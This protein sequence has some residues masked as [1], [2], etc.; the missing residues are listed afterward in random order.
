MEIKR[1]I[2]RTEASDVRDQL[3]VSRKQIFWNGYKIRNLKQIKKS[4]END[5]Q[6]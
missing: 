1:W 2:I 6:E 4:G 5:R 3:L